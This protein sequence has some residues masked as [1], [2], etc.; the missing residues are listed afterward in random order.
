MLISGDFLFLDADTIVTGELADIDDIECDIGA[1]LDY[2]CHSS[3]LQQYEIF[4]WM[5][6]EPMK[7]IFQME[8][9]SA[10][11]VYNSGV[12]LVRDTK[13]A[14][15]V[16][17]LWHKNWDISRRR[18]ECRDQ[19]ALAVTCQELNNPLQEISGKFNCQIR[20]SV[21]YLFD[22]K[23]LHTFA[24]QGDSEIS[25]LLGMDFYNDIAI[26]RGISP[27]FAERLI[28]CK[29]L[30]ISPSF[31]VGKKWL[32]VYFSPSYQLI[33][34]CMNSK[35]RVERLTLFWINNFSRF[36]LFA[37]RMYYKKIK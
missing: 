25:P 4:K 6:V 5:Y 27:T 13:Q 23:I 35:R 8:Y 29:R 17:T 16:F 7:E 11:D 19:L 12:L 15:D 21:E 2:H 28:E 9:C 3:E 18:G 24:S 14:H 37:L 32:G 10:T 34:K 1:V 30:F 36:L 22:C 26:N 33:E 20:L 31:L